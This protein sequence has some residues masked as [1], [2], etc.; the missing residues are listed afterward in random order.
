[1]IPPPRSVPFESIRYEDGAWPLTRWDKNLR[2]I[3]KSLVHKRTPWTE[4]DRLHAERARAY[5]EGRRWQ[6]ERRPGDGVL[7]CVLGGDLMWVR[8]GFGRVFSPGA[9]ALLE[10]ADLRVV[11]L[12]TPIV[13]ERSVPTYRYETLHYNA[14]PEYLDALEGPGI[15]LVSLC[16]NHALDQG[17]EGLARTREVVSERRLVPLGGPERGDELARVQ[18]DVGTRTVSLEAT[19]VTYGINHS[20]GQTPGGIPIARFG[21]PHAAGPPWKPRWPAD[22]A[23][24]RVLV[25]HWGYEYEYF[26]TEAQRR[27]ALEL[28]RAGC[29]LV[30]GSSPHVLQPVELVSIDGADPDCPL[31]VVRGGSPRFGVIAWSLGNLATIM[32]TLACRVGALVEIELLVREGEA[33]SPAAIRIHPTFSAR[34]L[35]EL[36]HGLRLGMNGATHLLSE[37][38]IAHPKARVFRRARAHAESI[39]GRLASRSAPIPAVH[40]TATS[41]PMTRSESPMSASFDPPL[42][43]EAIPMA[44]ASAVRPRLSSLDRAG[45]ARFLE[46]MVHYTRGSGA[47]LKHAARASADTPVAAFFAKLAEE[48]ASHYKLAEADLRDL[49]GE[50]S[51]DCPTSVARFDADW[52]K[53]GD[54]SAWLGALYALENVAGHLAADVPKELVRLGLEKSHVRFVMTHLS[55]D[56]EHGHDTATWVGRADR[57]KVVGAAREAARFWVELHLAAFDG[58]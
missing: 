32:P 15:S 40:S 13:P 30:V 49:G 16:N 6:A 7:R 57:T 58:R 41:N 23:D 19:A 11:N 3:G 18:M 10:C 20:T 53:A 31:Q 39:L 55:A 2:Y 8:S 45:Y 24:L 4:A 29:D 25:P 36:A 56:A 21:A 48:E 35:H 9:R 5:L 17:P 46:A 54:P 50:I 43:L 26:T 42:E 52:H 14:P 12:E 28:V 27:D 1:M 44:M 51:L 33:P 37:L 22:S 34:G 47:R 38:E